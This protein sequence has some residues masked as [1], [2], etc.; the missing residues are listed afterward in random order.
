MIEW[1]QNTVTLEKIVVEEWKRCGIKGDRKDVG[2]MMEN[3]G[4]KSHT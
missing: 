4:V 1:I 2:T 3:A